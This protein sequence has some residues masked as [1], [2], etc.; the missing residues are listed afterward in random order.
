M[1]RPSLLPSLLY[2]MFYM[3]LAFPLTFFLLV[4]LPV[5]LNVLSSCTLS[6]LSSRTFVLV[7]GLV[8]GVRM[9]VRSMSSCRTP[10]PLRCLLCFLALL[11][12]FL[13]CGIVDLAILVFLNLSKSCHSY[14]YLS[15]CASP[16]KW[17][18]I[19]A[20]LTQLVT[21][22]HPPMPLT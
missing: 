17:A 1:D 13:F 4:P 9:V 22:F 5:H 19:M 10:L 20:R 11:L 16:V 6:I 18:N 12:L 14:L 2:I 7:R 15:L 8:W 3:F 21:P